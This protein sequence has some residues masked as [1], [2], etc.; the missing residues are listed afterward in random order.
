MTLE[1]AKAK[2]AATLDE[3]C[4]AGFAVWGWDDESIQIRDGKS[5]KSTSCEARHPTKNP[6]S[7]RSE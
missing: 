4:D 6:P 1:E 5:G 7:S 2:L 3:L